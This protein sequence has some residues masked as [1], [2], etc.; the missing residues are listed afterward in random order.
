MGNKNKNLFGEKMTTKTPQE[1][2]DVIKK[3]NASDQV[4]IQTYLAKLKQ[5]IASLK[6]TQIHGHDE[7]V[8]AGHAHYHGHE[9]CYGD[10][11]HD[12]SLHE[13]ESSEH[14]HHAHTDHKHKEEGH[15]HSHH[16]HGDHK[17]KEDHGHSHHDHGDHK[18]KE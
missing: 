6:E 5:T 9:K 7:E 3:L 18:H 2:T 1:V 8:E 14:G 12:D 10:H 17:H 4:V 16:D 11:G 13:E 15:G